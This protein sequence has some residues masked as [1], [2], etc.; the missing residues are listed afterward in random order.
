MLG[1]YVSSM[2]ACGDRCMQ[3]FEIRHMK[4]TSKR[5]SFEEM[6]RFIYAFAKAIAPD[7]KPVFFVDVTRMKNRFFFRVK[8][9]DN[10]LYGLS[11]NRWNDDVGTFGKI[12]SLFK[13]ANPKTMLRQQVISVEELVY[14]FNIDMKKLVEVIF[15]RIK[16]AISDGIKSNY[17]SSSKMHFNFEYDYRLSHSSHPEAPLHLESTPDVSSIDELMIWADLKAGVH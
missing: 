8:T 4:T 12:D 3:V 5:H 1:Q 2:N 6:K 17:G 10:E 14:E 15:K 9:K 13:K 16:Q 11:Y 7:G